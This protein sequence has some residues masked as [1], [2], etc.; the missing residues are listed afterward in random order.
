MKN[1][2]GLINTSTTAQK[3]VEE[4]DQDDAVDDSDSSVEFR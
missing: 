3:F 1:C 4:D 2:E